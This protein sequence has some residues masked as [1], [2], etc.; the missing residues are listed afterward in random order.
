MIEKIVSAYLDLAENR[1]QR[2][3]VMNMED[4][5]EF[6]NKFLKLSDYPI[7]TH[8]GKVSALKAE[9]KAETEYDKFRIRY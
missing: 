8:K 6:L 7:L 1:A 3:V 5:E 9:I 4:W 2:S